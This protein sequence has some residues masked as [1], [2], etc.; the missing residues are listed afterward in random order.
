MHFTMTIWKKQHALFAKKKEKRCA[1]SAEHAYHTW[2]VQPWRSNQCGNGKGLCVAYNILKIKKKYNMKIGICGIIRNI[3][4]N[5]Q[6][7]HTYC[8]KVKEF[9]PIWMC[10]IYLPHS[11]FW[12]CQWQMQVK[13]GLLC[14]SLVTNI[15]EEKPAQLHLALKLTYGHII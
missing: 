9:L 15:I 7:M 13:N 8:M 2:I 5:I 3:N 14:K 11:P 4:V 1:F 10:R 12:L 6:Q